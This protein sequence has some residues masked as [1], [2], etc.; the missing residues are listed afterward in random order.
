MPL[1]DLVVFENVLQIQ[2]TLTLLDG[3]KRRPATHGVVDECEW[4]GFCHCC[5]CLPEAIHGQEVA[6]GHKDHDYLR[7]LD[8]AF[9]RINGLKVLRSDAET[10]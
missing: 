4:L 8:V 2:R 7:A 9:E 3:L 1:D 10:A 5:A 6:L